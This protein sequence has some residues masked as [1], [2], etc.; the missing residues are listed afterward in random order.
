MGDYV[1]LHNELGDHI[2]V[3]QCTKRQSLQDPYIAAALMRSIEDWPVKR[4]Y[5]NQTRFNTP[6]SLI[7]N[8]LK[9]LLMNMWIYIG[10]LLQI[11]NNIREVLHDNPQNF[12]TANFLNFL[13]ISWVNGSFWT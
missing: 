8:V 12:N 4:N 2:H 6:A 1:Q 10:A 7:S 9:F 5:S 3:V 13:D 11:E